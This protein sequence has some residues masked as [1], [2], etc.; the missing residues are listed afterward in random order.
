[1]GSLHEGGGSTI[2]SYI[3]ARGG[4][5]LREI[6]SK[7]MGGGGG[8]QEWVRHFYFRGYGSN[9]ILSKYMTVEYKKGSAYKSEYGV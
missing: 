5:G 2:Y 4:G 6:L 7:D 8:L 3:F 1:M 9:N